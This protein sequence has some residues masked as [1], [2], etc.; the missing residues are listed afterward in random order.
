MVDD[1]VMMMDDMTMTQPTKLPS[2][3]PIYLPTYLPT[4]LA[5]YL[6]MTHRH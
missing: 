6:G 5:T 1:M 4:Y 2:Y 3:L